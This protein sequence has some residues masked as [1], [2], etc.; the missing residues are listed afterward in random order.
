MLHLGVVPEQSALLAHFQN[1]QVGHA[2][3]GSWIMS[4]CRRLRVG[5]ICCVH[6]PG[7]VNNVC[8]KNIQIVSKYLLLVE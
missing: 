2:G 4:S 5:G 6:Y 7:P 3:V 8:F 1:A